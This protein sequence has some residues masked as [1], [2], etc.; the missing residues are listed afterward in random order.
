MADQS[1]RQIVDSYSEHPLRGPL[2]A[3]QAT[4]S[5]WISRTTAQKKKVMGVKALH[6]YLK[7]HPF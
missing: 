3:K 1:V 7:I 2:Y 4:L 5:I 6:N